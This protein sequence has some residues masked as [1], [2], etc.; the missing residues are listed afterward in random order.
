M[1]KRMNNQGFSIIAITLII[2]VFLIIGGT[3][4]LV[5]S[6]YH[7][8]PSTSPTTASGNSFKIVGNK[9]ISPNGSRFVPYGFVVPCAAYTNEGSI[10]RICQGYD[11]SQN[12]ATAEINAAATYWH[13]NILRFQLAQENLFSG[14]N[15][16]VNQSYV[17]LVDSLVSQAN[18]HGMVADLTL[19]EELAGGLAF[20]SAS[21]LAFWQ[22]MAT[23]FKNNPY[24]FFDLYNEPQLGVKAAGSEANIWNIWRNGGTALYQSDSKGLGYSQ[25][26]YVGMQT[27]ADAIRS[28]GANNI[29]IAESN[30]KDQSLTELPTHY[31][32]GYNIAYGV[33]PSPKHNKTQAEMY[34]N[35]G[36]YQ[37]HVAIV[38]DAFIDT[39]GD[40]SCDPNSPVDVPNILNYLKD[41]GMGVIYWTLDPGVGIVGNNLENP[42]YYPTGVSSIASNNCPGTHSGAIPTNAYGPGAIIHSFYQAN[43]IQF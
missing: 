39:Y 13:A 12:S 41:I 1:L 9:I 7:H 4:W 26:N 10:S 5:Y 28:E 6:H 21:S 32:S 17:N 37:Q 25:V 22:F 15:G 34:T 40:A 16:S 3:F 24:V 18:S 20:P 14:P 30:N 33:E 23:H 27:L 31:L 43:S 19:Q 2:I 38:P 29:I 42:T 36:Q 11:V 35:F 8:K